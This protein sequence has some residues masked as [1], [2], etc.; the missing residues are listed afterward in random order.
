MQTTMALEPRLECPCWPGKRFASEGSLRTHRLSQRHQLFDARLEIADLRRQLTQS[1][2]ARAA[3]ERTVQEL[4]TQ[5]RLRRVTERVKKRIAAAQ[6]WKCAQCDA[7][8][9]ATYQIDHR[10]PLWQ[11]G[12]NEPDNLQA[13]CPNCHATKTQA[14]SGG[15]P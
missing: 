14:E 15:A 13:L 8:L 12:S 5:P 7:M 10:I 4:A 1:T 6:R 11:G 2:N 3:L 9:D